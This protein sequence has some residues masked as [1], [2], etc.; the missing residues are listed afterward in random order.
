MRTQEVQDSVAALLTA[1]CRYKN[2]EAN[3]AEI[4]QWLDVL[5]NKVNVEMFGNVGA[6]VPFKPFEHYPITPIETNEVKVYALGVRA[7][8]DDGSYR[9]L[10]KALVKPM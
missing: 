6:V 8:R 3:E 9:V 1:W 2:G 4:S 7:M 10:T 5:A